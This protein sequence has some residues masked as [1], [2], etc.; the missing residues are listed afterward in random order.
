M[1]LP[2]VLR[3]EAQAEFDRAFDWY[4]QQRKGLGVEFLKVSATHRYGEIG[5]STI[6][7]AEQVTT[8]VISG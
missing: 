3:V 1:S 6:N 5:F 2:I 7:A 8:V 4:E